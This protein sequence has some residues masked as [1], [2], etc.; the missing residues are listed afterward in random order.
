M[1]KIVAAGSIIVDK[2][3]IIDAYPH[4]GELVQ[5]RSRSRAG[6]G[7]VHNTGRDIRKFAPE[8][9]VSAFGKVGDDEDGRF[10]TAELESSGIDVS[11]VK[12]SAS[13]GTSFTDVMSV[14]GGERTFF[15]YAGACAEWGY[16][17]FPFEAVN[18]GDI[19][20]MGY[21]LLLEK[22]DAGDG[23]RILKELKRRGAMTAIDLVTENSDRYPLVRECLPYVDYLIINEIEAARIAGVGD[24]APAELCRR[25]IELGVRERVVV[26]MPEK[27]VTLRRG[28]EAAELPS[29]DIPSEL[30]LGKTG[31]GDAYCAGALTGIYRGLSDLEILELGGLAAIGALTQPGA[32]EGMKTE[33]ELRE[34]AGKF[35]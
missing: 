23:L 3:N 5:I 2:I 26:H 13:A 12:V 32:V 35:K 27:G 31:A 8:I 33:G 25:L 11:G 6:G 21:F 16:D 19:V 9:P 14:S 17:D 24:A 18:P 7:L 30:I 20:L 28:A 4:A 15:A 34:Y 1:K 22:I 10:V 29:I